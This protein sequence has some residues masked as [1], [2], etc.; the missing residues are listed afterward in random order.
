VF[1]E[2]RWMA[3][4][5]TCSLRSAAERILDGILD[6]ARAAFPDAVIDLEPVPHHPGSYRCRIN[7]HPTHALFQ[8]ED[9]VGRAIHGDAATVRAEIEKRIRR[10][11][12]RVATA[13]PAPVRR[14][15]GSG[16]DARP[17]PDA[18]QVA[19]RT[20]TVVGAGSPL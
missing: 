3:S 2:W 12:V 11:V 17:R 15:A 14:V 9:V 7:G 19:V 8:I 6:E 5:L 20:G 13:V 18:E 10:S 1:L 4:L 16:I